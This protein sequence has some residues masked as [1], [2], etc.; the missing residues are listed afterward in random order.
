MMKVFFGIRLSPFQGLELELVFIH[1]ASHYANAWALS[2]QFLNN[3][4]YKPIL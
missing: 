1:S 3:F 4:I 2:E